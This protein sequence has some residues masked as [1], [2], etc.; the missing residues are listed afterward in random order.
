MSHAT[1]CLR[2]ATVHWSTGGRRR[3]P[4]ASLPWARA[5]PLPCGGAWASRCRSGGVNPWWGCAPALRRR[6]HASRALPSA[7]YPS[8]RHACGRARGASTSR[9]VCRRAGRAWGHP[10][11]LG[12]RSRAWVMRAGV[13]RP[14]Q[15]ACHPS[16]SQ[17]CAGASR[18]G[19]RAPRARRRVSVRP[20][21]QSA[22]EPG[23]QG[24]PPPVRRPWPQLPRPRSPAGEV[25]WWRRA[26]G[27]L[28]S[29]RD[30]AASQVAAL[31]RAGTGTA[32]H[33]SAGADG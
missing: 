10:A 9:R 8:R 33:S 26:M 12:A 16:V 25:V 19:P 28:R 3:G 32:S 4:N 6:A 27:P 29:Q 1:R 20:R 23:G 24:R 15:R 13:L 21:Q 17:A 18:A 31:R 30:G 5:A 7:R 14:R 11:P 22:W 2:W